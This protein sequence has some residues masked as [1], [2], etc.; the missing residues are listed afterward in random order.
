MAK[1]V[2]DAKL[3]TRTAREQLKPRDKPYYRAIDEGLT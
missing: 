3:E 2:R 1:T